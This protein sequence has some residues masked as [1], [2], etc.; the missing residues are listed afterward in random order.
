M[1]DARA[2][3]RRVGDA[4]YLELGYEALVADAP[5]SLREVCRFAGLEYDDGMLGYVGETESARK[6]HQQR[7]NEPPRV[8]VRDWRTE[9]APIDRRGLR[10]R[11]RRPPRRARV[12]DDVTRLLRRTARRLSCDDERLA[13]HW[14]TDAAI[15]ALAPPSSPGRPSWFLAANAPGAKRADVGTDLAECPGQ[16][17]DVGVAQVAGEVLLDPVPVMAPRTLH[18]RAAIVREDDEDRTAVV[19]RPDAADEAGRFHP[20]DDTRE[21]ALAVEDPVR[22]LVHPEAAGCLLELNEDVVPAHR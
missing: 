11:R 17:R 15:A 10:V 6:A 13:R 9:M 14:G 12:R 4:R 16:R 8:G 19:L 21:T 22:E 5:G 20:V 1:R 3:G 18:R 2:L 7:L